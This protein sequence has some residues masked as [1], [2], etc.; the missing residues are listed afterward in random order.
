VWQVIFYTRPNGRRPAQ[1]WIDSQDNSIRPSIDVR[2]QKLRLE[3]QLLVENDMLVPIR[4]KPGGRL[5]PGFYE[6]KD[7]GRKWR[8]A[9]Y[10]DLN[11]DIFVLIWGWR[12][13]RQ[14]Q[15]QDVRR[16]LKL[17]EEYKFTEGE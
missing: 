2:I 3:G 10:H 11:K 17:L 5:V 16:A 15:E 13:S 1:E 9:T 14:S 6:L 7:R 12:K 8:I 4:E